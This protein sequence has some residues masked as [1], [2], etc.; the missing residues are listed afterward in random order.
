[1]TGKSFHQAC[2]IRKN[3]IPTDEVQRAA[4]P[5]TPRVAGAFV[6]FPKISELMMLGVYI[7]II[8]FI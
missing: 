8:C 2:I 3:S 6:K 7:H 4:F 5:P 1:M